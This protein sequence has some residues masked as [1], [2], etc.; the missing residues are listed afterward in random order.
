VPPWY[1]GPFVTVSAPQLHWT[2]TVADW[3][4]F[5][6]YHAARVQAGTHGL[7]C[8]YGF[9]DP[10][11]TRLVVDVTRPDGTVRSVRA[12][13]EVPV[14][15]ARWAALPGDVGRYEVS[16]RQGPRSAATSF[17]VVPADAPHVL[18]MRRGQVVGQRVRLGSSMQVVVTGLGPGVRFAL[19]L[20][21]YT[22]KARS[23]Q[24]G[25]KYFNTL[26]LQASAA[27]TLAFRFRTSKRDRPG[28]YRIALRLQQE[29]LDIAS[30]TMVR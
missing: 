21:R 3:W 28:S 26:D 11:A 15:I 27:G 7:L 1:R 18:I 10:S 30:F 17:T 8:F 25:F 16:A 13:S 14:P 23:R 2:R 22:T 20:Y 12:Q 9:E 24:P 5:E 29:A 4:W 6:S 19:D